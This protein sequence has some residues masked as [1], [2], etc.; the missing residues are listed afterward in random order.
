MT[1][2]A[3]YM[4]QRISATEPDAPGQIDPFGPLYL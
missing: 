1:F 3:L 4:W 2:C